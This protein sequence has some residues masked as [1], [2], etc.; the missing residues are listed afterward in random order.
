MKKD[1]LRLAEHDPNVQYNLGLLF[2]HGQGVARDPQE[3]KHWFEKAAEGGNVDAQLMLGILSEDPDLALE[4]LRRAARQDCASAQYRLGLLLRDDPVEAR[5]WLRCAA[6][7]GLSG[8]QL[9]LH[10]LDALSCDR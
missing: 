4:W 9:A 1:L 8:A 7:Q 5:H 3:A 2:H 10:E 6:D